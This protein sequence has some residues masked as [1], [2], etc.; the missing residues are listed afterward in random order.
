[1]EELFKKLN[2]Q[3]STLTSKE[4]ENPEEVIRSFFDNHP[5]HCTRTHLWELYKG[6][7]YHSSEY[8]DGE[9]SKTMLSFYTQ[10]ILLLEASFVCVE[11]KKGGT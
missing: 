7:L 9:I 6:W 4:L 1:M 3:P 11:K 8:A 10:I 2:Y 5:I